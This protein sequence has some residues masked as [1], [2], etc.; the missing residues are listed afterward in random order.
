MVGFAIKATWDLT[1]IFFG[2]IFLPVIL[3]GLVAAGF[4]GL[5]LPILVIVGIVMLVKKAVVSIC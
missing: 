5:A 1:K 4:V 2:L 3:I